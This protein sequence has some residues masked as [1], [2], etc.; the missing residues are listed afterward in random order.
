[1]TL[2]ELCEPAF[3]YVCWLNH[4]VRS[5]GEVEYTRLKNDVKEILDNISYKAEHDPVLNA[6]YAKVKMPLIFFVDSML[7]ESGVGC[8]SQWNNNR[9]SYDFNELAGDEA[10][11]DYLDRATEQID[12]EDVEVLAFY[13]TCLGL[14]FSGFYVGQSELLRQ[15]MSIIRPR[16]QTLGNFDLTSKLCQKAYESVNTTD[17]IERPTSRVLGIAITFLGLTFVV[18]L[19]VIMTFRSSVGSLNKAVEEIREQENRVTFVAE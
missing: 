9:L 12:S 8:A 14:G 2:T 4:V 18:F 19:A 3:Q 16:I 13:Y 10:F 11:F 7:V 1:M 6:K 5:G 17:L 15:K